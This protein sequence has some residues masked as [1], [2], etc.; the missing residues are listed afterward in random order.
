MVDA[1]GVEDAMDESLLDDPDP[2][3]PEEHAERPSVAAAA[4]PRTAMR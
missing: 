1:L 2:L 3:V 4:S